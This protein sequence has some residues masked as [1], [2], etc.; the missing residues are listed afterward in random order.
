MDKAILEAVAEFTELKSDKN[1]K[2]SALVKLCEDY[3]A[4]ISYRNIN[5]CSGDFYELFWLFSPEQLADISAGTK[6][7]NDF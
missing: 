3:A 4:R 5:L 2:L 7:Y 1:Y 6:T